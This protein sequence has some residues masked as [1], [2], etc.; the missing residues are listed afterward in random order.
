MR[1]GPVFLARV[2]RALCGP[3]RPALPSLP[4]VLHGLFFTKMIF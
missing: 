3:A 4:A 2:V 1:G